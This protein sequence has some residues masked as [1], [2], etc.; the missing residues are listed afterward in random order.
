MTT[1]GHCYKTFYGRKLR[2]FIIS[3]SNCPCQA[4]QPSLMFAIKA[5]VYLIEVPFQLYGRLLESRL[6]E[7]RLLEG[8]LLEGRLL[9]GRLL[10]GRLLASPTNIRIGWKGLPGTNAIAYY[11]KT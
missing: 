9:E 1:R 5:G 6:L 7:G 3:K 10:E 8:R 2:L 11:Q 4:F